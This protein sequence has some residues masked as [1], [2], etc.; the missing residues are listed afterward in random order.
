MS[1]QIRPAGL[2][3]VLG[4]L[5]AIS[6]CNFPVNTTPTEPPQLLVSN[7]TLD[8]GAT[9][10]TFL[11][12]ATPTDTLNAVSSLG[13][14]TATVTQ[15][16][17]DCLD[18]AAFISDVTITDN[19]ELVPGEMFIKIWRLENTGTCIWTS[20]YRLSFFGGDRMGGELD[21]PLVADVAPGE[22]VEVSVD[23]V[24]PEQPGVYQGLWKLRNA[25]SAF[26]GIGPTGDLSFWVKIVVLA[27]LETATPTSTVTLTEQA[28][29]TG[30]PTQ[31][32]TGTPSAT[33]D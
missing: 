3:G 20:E 1:L 2:A 27:P 32:P 16:S 33:S 29:S 19:S 11:V 4:L 5:L 30:T 13:G 31:T 14:A 15:G 6:A 24:A 8:S 12:S 28:L 9:L 26:F 18:R 22:Q 21:I 17:E 23:L 7:P 10:S 25:Q